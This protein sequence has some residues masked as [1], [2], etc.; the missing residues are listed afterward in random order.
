MGELK[1]IFCFLWSMQAFLFSERRAFLCML[2]RS[3]QRKRKKVVLY[4]I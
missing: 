4:D 2:T 3:L 1:F